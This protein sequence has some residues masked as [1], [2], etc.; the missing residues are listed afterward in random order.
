MR[1]G[2]G[3]IG[4][5]NA[6]P[7]PVLLPQ[8]RLL[9]CE[10]CSKLSYVLGLFNGGPLAGAVQTHVPL[11]IGQLERLQRIPVWREVFFLR[12]RAIS[13]ARFV[14]SV[15]AVDDRVDRCA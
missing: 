12:N 14:G 4:E 1:G 13:L 2:L 8:G 7:A 3:S 5:K 11:L 15:V 9:Y 10:C 6:D